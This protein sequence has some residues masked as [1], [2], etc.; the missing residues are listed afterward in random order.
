MLATG[1][2]DFHGG[3]L[4]DILTLGHNDAP[5]T[6]ADELFAEIGASRVSKLLSR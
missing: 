1:G 3:G 5:D 2:S 6:V 4:T